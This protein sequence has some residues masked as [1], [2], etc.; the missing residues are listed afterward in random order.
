MDTAETTPDPVF[1]PIQNLSNILN[2]AKAA[3]D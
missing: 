1:S 3:S 2:Q